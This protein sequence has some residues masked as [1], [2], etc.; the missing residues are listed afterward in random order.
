MRGL[1]AVARIGAALAVALALAAPAAAQSFSIAGVRFD[2]SV[3]LDEATL[4]GIADRYTNRPIGFADLQSMVEAVNRA[5]ALAGVV[6]ALAVLPP[7]DITD[8][9]LHVRLIEARVEAVDSSALTRTRADFIRDAIPLPTGAPVDFEQLEIDLRRFE[10]AHDFRP[11]VSFGPG[12]GEGM[13]RAEI[14]GD[15]PPRF[16]H[17]F[18]ADNYGS[19]QTGK[20]RGAWFGRWNSVTGRRDI[21]SVQLQKSRGAWSGGLGYSLPAFGQGGRVVVSATH[22]RSQVISAPFLPVD[23]RSTS[24]SASLGYIRPFRIGPDRHWTVSADIQVERNKS[25]ISDLPLLRTDLRDAAIGL[26]WQRRFARSVLGVSLG[27]RGGRADTDQTSE[28]EG[29]YWL[30]FGNASYAR[31]LG[32]WGLFS[33]AMSYQYAHGQNL[34]VAR[35]FNAGGASSVRGYPNAV[36][37]GDSGL[38]MQNQISSA[39]GFEIGT[40][41]P[42][43]LSPFAFV[44]AAV[45][46][47]YRVDGGVDSDQ[48]YLASVGFGLR[49]EF[50]DRGTALLSYGVPLRNTLGFDDKGKGTLYFGLD[51]S[52]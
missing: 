35:L 43:A 21:L 28:T 27:V 47:P 50:G 39:R 25:E 5:Y 33:T 19:P 48:D 10:I 26:A 12:E 45:I 13:T 42:V 4:N 24:S 6:T 9:V 41:Y 23:I 17:V 3:Y 11:V 16:E 31:L 2:D 30:A 37:S 32:D 20:A 38:I 36:R 49:A 34:P 7:Q 44:D 1:Q 46:V 29:S 52:F 18:S 8:G 15:E 22:A 14:G 40:G 51:M